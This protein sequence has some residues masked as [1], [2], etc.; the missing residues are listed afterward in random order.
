MPA[1]LSEPKATAWCGKQS[2]PTT[3]NA[4]GREPDWSSIQRAGALAAEINVD[5]LAVGVLDFTGELTVPG[6][7]DTKR[8]VVLAAP[9]LGWAD[10]EL[11]EGL[12]KLPP[13]APFG[14]WALVAG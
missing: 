3:A 11:S 13:E 8:N 12:P 9:N 5:C 7:V 6:V 4:D 1:F 14:V 2:S 10:V